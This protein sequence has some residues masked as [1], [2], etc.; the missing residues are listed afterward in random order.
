[1]KAFLVDVSIC[2]GCYN[3]Q[4]ACKDEHCSNDWAPIAAPQP[5]TGQFWMKLNEHIRGTVPKV[6]M[7]YVPVLCQHCDEAPCM[8]AAPG[9][10]YKREDGMVVI[11]PAKAAGDKAI[12][13]SCPYGVIY[14]NEELQLAQKCTGCAHLLDRGWKE[15][16]CVD[17]CPTGAITFGEES[18]L[19][20]EGT[21]PLLRGA[22]GKP[23]VYYKNIPKTF[24]GGTLYDPTKK[25][26]VEDA[27]ITLTT[28]GGHTQTAR[29]NGWGDF[30]FE[31]L[32]EGAYDLSISAS[33]YQPKV[34]AGIDTREN[35]ANLGDIALV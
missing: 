28:A 9:E 8:E 15:P 35:S 34:L 6:K 3:C 24:I 11:D 13:K 10:I 30:W 5:E 14:W 4:I 1:M 29:S 20:I 27:T 31:G 23:R 17:A 2:N 25:E 12:V 19:D 33:G 7:H 22:P 16:R 26:I 21:E 32:E 18:E